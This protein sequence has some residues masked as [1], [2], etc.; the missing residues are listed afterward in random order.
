MIE[1]G[2]V[3]AQPGGGGDRLQGRHVARGGEHDVRGIV[4]AIAALAWGVHILTALN[5]ILAAFGPLPSM[6]R[7]T[8]SLISVAS[9]LFDLHLE[10]D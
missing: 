2:R 5:M 3:P 7:M 1:P 8:L 6:T 4:G 9:P 10:I